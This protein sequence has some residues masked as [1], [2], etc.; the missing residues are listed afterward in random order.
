MNNYVIWVYQLGFKS[1]NDKDKKIASKYNVLIQDDFITDST[2]IIGGW[3]SVL[4]YLN[5]YVGVEVVND[6][7]KPF[8][9]V[10]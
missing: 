10:G 7:L 8:K 1:L 9:M 4:N 3:D 5:N 6:Y 2:Y